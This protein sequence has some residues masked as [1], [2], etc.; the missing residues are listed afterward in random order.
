MTGTNTKQQVLTDVMDPA[1]AA[2]LHA[3]LGLDGPPPGSGDGLP[4]FWHHIYF[5]NARPPGELGQDGHPTVGQGMVP[6][7]GLPQRMWAGGR[8]EFIA[9]LRLG[10]PAT[11]TTRQVSATRKEGRSGPLGFVVLEHEISQDGALCL[12]EFHDIVYRGPFVGER[13][14]RMAPTDETHCEERG[15]D[16]VLLFR[17]SALTFNGHRI[18]YDQ[19][20]A[21]GVEG[22]DGLVVH[23]PLLAQYLMLMAE[24]LGGPM[25]RFTF[26]ATA[27]LMHHERAAFCASGSRFWVR[28][29]DG[30]LCMSG[31]AEW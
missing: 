31:E 30:R 26:R 3:T 29:P 5:W 23:G 2:A 27:A 9:P 10:E 7:M 15:F 24:R 12:R 20:H 16:P 28:G 4:P 8:L 14:I 17:Y 19:A 21:T 11:K 13:A 22:Y 25:K 18:H 6:D 1:R